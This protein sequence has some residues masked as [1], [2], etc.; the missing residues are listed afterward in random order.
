MVTVEHYLAQL[1]LRWFRGKPKPRVDVHQGRYVLVHGT[2]PKI[3][4]VVC[5]AGLALIGVIPFVLGP[6]LG[7]AV[8]QWL[9]RAFGVT[10]WLLAAMNVLDSFF[11]RVEVDEST[12]SN[13]VPW[14]GVT[15]VPWS[16]VR[17]VTRVEGFSWYSIDAGIY[18]R[19]RFSEFIDGAQT[20]LDDA[21]R[22]GIPCS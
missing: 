16:D 18:G 9:W 13:F 12:I 17:R 19:V 3:V 6:Q 4:A 2:W 11:S 10:L 20:F 14:R 21:A 8:T 7:N 1:F 15:K 5:F 22:R